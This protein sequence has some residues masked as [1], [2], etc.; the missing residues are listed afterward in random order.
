[1]CGGQ[2]TRTVLLEMNP[3]HAAALALVGWYLMMLP[4]SLAADAKSKL[5]TYTNKAY[6][7]SFRYPSDW[8]L[9]EGEPVDLSWGYLG[10]VESSMPHGTM[11]A[12]VV[13]PHEPDDGDNF[14]PYFLSVSIDSGLAADACGRFAPNGPYDVPPQPG[15]PPIVKLGS[16][17]FAQAA[18]DDGGL[19]H[20]R[21]ARYY[22][23]FRNRTCYEIEIGFVAPKD[24]ET[25]DEHS[26][27][28][29]FE[30][31]NPILATITIRPT[32]IL[33]RWYLMIPR[34]A[35]DGGSDVTPPLI[36]WD[37]HIFDSRHDCESALEVA[38]LSEEQGAAAW[39]LRT[40][41]TQQ[42]NEALLYSRDWV[43]V[44]SDDPR[45]KE[46]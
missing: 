14:A 10:Q 13:A 25:E 39:N 19:G 30:V 34:I 1:M 6:G 26:E 27:N 2:F 46:K 23:V 41:L 18:D 32:T 40:G 35:K 37:R 20:Q 45:L 36:Q 11:V 21:Y 33:P 28:V 31:I 15:T 24:F 16:I 44:A 12:A 29:E 42:Q 8:T 5:T 3:R 22:R 4:S 43:C 17:S 9:K 7:F 38:H